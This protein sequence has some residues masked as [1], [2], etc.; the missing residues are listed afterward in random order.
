MRTKNMLFFSLALCY[1]MPHM[2]SISIICKPTLDTFARFGVVLAA[3]FGFGLYFFYDASIG[4][5]KA[6]EAFCSYHAFSQLGQKISDHSKATWTAERATSPLLAT[7]M[8]DGVLNGIHGEHRYP[9]PQQCAAAQTCPPEAADYDSMNK[10]WNDCW[11]AYSARMHFPITPA[12]HG[13]DAATIRE[14]WYAGG[15]CMIIS[16]ILVALMIRTAKRT[17]RLE[18]DTVTA[19]GQSFKVSDITRLDLRQWSAGYKGVAYATVKGKRVRLDGMTYGGF[20]KDKGEPAEQWMQALL[21][22][23]KGEII[24]YEKT[25]NQN[26]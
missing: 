8:I 26:S 25:D 7:E 21:A 6:N 1:A 20:N 16:V 5:Y 19:A 4:Y 10:S 17:M 2:T 3:F 24:D 23:Y 14:Q 13:H 9:L 15:V 22:Q 18:G 11:A 12:E